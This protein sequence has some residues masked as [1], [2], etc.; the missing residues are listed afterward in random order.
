MY[1]VLREIQ[2]RVGADKFPLIP[3][4]FYSSHA[5]VHSHHASQPLVQSQEPAECG[6]A[7]LLW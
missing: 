4:N 7:H 2:K 6:G 1:G 3:I 5:Y